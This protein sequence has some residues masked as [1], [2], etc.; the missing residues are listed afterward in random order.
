MDGLRT[1]I[2]GR[3]A[4]TGL[5]HLEAINIR[6]YSDNKHHK[7]DD[8]PYGGGAGM[9]MQAQPVYGAYQSV[10]ERIGR[11]PRCIYATPRAGRLPKKMQR[12]LRRNRI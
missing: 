3:A 12:I 1:S 2:I 7:V 4:E 10:I 9:L 8:Y 6:D 5:L 11:K